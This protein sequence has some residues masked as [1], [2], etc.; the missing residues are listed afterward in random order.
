MAMLTPQVGQDVI[1]HVYAVT[2]D[3]LGDPLESSYFSGTYPMRSF[4]VGTAEY[5]LR[6]AVDGWMY[7]AGCGA[8]NFMVEALGSFVVGQANDPEG[9]REDWQNQVHASFQQL[10][11]KRPFEMNDDDRALWRALEDIIDSAEY[12]RSTPVRMRQLGRVKYRS[13]PYP[14]AVNWVG[15][16]NESVTFQVMPPE[17]PSFKSGQWIEAICERD[18]LTGRLL[19][20]SH[21]ERIPVVRMLNRQQQDGYWESLSTSDSLPESNLDWTRFD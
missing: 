2:N 3:M 19:R 8:F 7:R 14:C 12:R 4:R 10:L 5:R 6:R 21:V 17:F 13:L 20:V 1:P 15:G 18:P 9:A 16:V 11:A